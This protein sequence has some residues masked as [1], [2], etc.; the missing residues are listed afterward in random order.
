MTCCVLEN[1]LCRLVLMSS[2]IAR[3]ESRDDLL[4]V[5]EYI[6]Q[7]GAD[8]QP[9]IPIIFHKFLCSEV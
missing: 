9:A 1:T 3:Q 5:K 4:C 7:V 2:H 6:L 8:E